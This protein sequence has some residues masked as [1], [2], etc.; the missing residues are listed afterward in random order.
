MF[1]DV[2]TVLRLK[3]EM[4]KQQSSVTAVHQMQILNNYYKTLKSLVVW[5]KQPF[6]AFMCLKLRYNQLHN[7]FCTQP[8]C[9]RKHSNTIEELCFLF[10]VPLGYCHL[11]G[12]LHPILPD[13]FPDSALN[14]K[15]SQMELIL[16]SSVM[17]FL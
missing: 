6:Y 12:E 2:M 14:L 10:L 16:L 7:C 4:I 17:Q 8:F 9:L 1:S 5:S 11:K 3:E 15:C 13:C